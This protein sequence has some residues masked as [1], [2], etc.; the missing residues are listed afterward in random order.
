[1]H[2]NISFHLFSRLVSKSLIFPKRHHQWDRCRDTEELNF[3][4]TLFEKKLQLWNNQQRMVSKMWKWKVRVILH[5]ATAEKFR[6]SLLFYV[7]HFRFRVE[8]ILFCSTAPILLYTSK[9]NNLFYWM[10]YRLGNK[11]IP[12]Y[13]ISILEMTI[14][15]AKVETSVFN[16]LSLIDFNAFVHAFEYVL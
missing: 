6:S 1:M 14:P 2:C 12:S 11:W 13:N 8:M 4:I 10:H 5:F 3:A 7:K 9:F 15:F 16:S